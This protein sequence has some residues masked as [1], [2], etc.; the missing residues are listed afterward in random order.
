VGRGWG[1]KRKKRKKEKKKAASIANEIWFK[2]AVIHF[3]MKW[4]RCILHNQ[5]YITER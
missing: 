4:L 1:G 2:I 5:K 3:L